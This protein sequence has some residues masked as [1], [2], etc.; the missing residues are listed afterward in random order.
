ME[1]NTAYIRRY[2]QAETRRPSDNSL[3]QTDV[4]AASFG[5]RQCRLCG[6]SDFP[7]HYGEGCALQLM[8][9][10][11]AASCN[12]RRKQPPT[13]PCMFE[14]SPIFLL[15]ALDCLSQA[16]APPAQESASTGPQPHGPKRI[17]KRSTREPFV[18]AE[19][20]RSILGCC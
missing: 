10:G 3:V 20:R 7:V 17:R 2:C 6:D 13:L 12:W 16:A 11:W 8:G 4:L 19:H 15:Y 1:Q 14:K 18:A 5:P 9:I